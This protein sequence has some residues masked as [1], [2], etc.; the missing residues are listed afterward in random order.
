LIS[1]KGKLK[2][3]IFHLPLEYV[4][5]K[6]KNTKEWEMNGLPYL[7]ADVDLL[8]ENILQ[9][10]T[11]IVES[12]GLVSDHLQIVITSIYSAISNSYGPQFTTARTEASQSAV[13][14][15]VVAC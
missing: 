8:G 10:E 13:S 15:P 4:T 14:S 3:T 7:V 2:K 12:S 11:V 1:D 6:V 9:R 5:M